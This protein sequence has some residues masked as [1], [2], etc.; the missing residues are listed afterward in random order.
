MRKIVLSSKPIAAKRS[1]SGCFP[2]V[3][4][5]TLFESMEQED[6]APHI[7][8]KKI[9]KKTADLHATICKRLDPNISI[10]KDFIEVQICT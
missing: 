2:D 7:Q 5:V 3:V 10:W 4:F 8:K 6:Q 1:K 9:C